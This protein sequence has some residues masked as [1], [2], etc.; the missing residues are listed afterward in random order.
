M[1]HFV[2]D[3]PEAMELQYFLV[4]LDD[5]QHLIVVLIADDVIDEINAG[6]LRE[7]SQRFVVRIRNG[8]KAGQERASV[9]ATLDKRVCA[10]AIGLNRRQHNNTMLVLQLV[11]RFHRNCTSLN[12]NLKA[13]RRTKQHKMVL[14]FTY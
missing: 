4:P 1:N 6:R 12:C 14:R 13:N 10:V 9:V 5:G 8:T 2:V 11:W 3:R 7:V